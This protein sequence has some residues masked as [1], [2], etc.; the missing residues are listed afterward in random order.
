[1]IGMMRD[2]G[3]TGMPMPLAKSSAHQTT[4]R[5]LLILLLAL[6]I[7][8]AASAAP[9]VACVP[10]GK[11][12]TGLAHK[13]CDDVVTAAPVTACCVVSAP[14][15]RIGSTESRLIASPQTATPVRVS[16][17]SLAPT[18]GLARS[19]SPPTLRVS[20]L[21]LYLQQSSLLI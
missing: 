19:G 16:A 14:I 11:A 8:G 17:H 4:M 18:A 1:M 3:G 7:A 21:P 10:Q 5:R 12:F 9:T 15:Q 13:C 20:S 2:A 6:T